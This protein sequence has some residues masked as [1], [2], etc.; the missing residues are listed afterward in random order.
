MR[1]R[2]IFAVLIVLAIEGLGLSLLM[3]QDGTIKVRINEA[4]AFKKNNDDVLDP[5]QDFYAINSIDGGAPFFTPEIGSRDDASWSNQI[6][7]KLV[8][9]RNQRFFDFYF[10]LWDRDT[11]CFGNV[12]DGFDISPQ[13]GPPGPPAPGGVFVPTIVTG[14]NPHVTYDVCTGKMQVVGVFG[15]NPIPIGSNAAEVNGYNTAPG[16]P[17]N[18]GS[19]RFDVVREPANWLPDD[20]AIDWVQIVQSV[21]K[22][23]RAVADKDTSLIVEI[24]STHPFP[25]TAPVHGQMTDGI[26]TVL[27]TKMVLIAPGSVATPG[28]TLVS[29]FDGNPTQPFKPQKSFIAGTGKVSGSASVDYAETISPNAPPQLMDCANLNNVGQATDLPL[30]HTSDPLTVFERFDYEEDQ[31][32]MTSPQLQ[33]MYTREET[34]RLASWPIANLNSSPT[35]NETWFDHGSDCLLCFEPFNTLVHYNAM[36]AQAGIDR[37]VLSVRNKWFAENAF[38]HQFIGAGSVGYSLGWFAPRA[39]L[40]EDGFYGVS[41]HE[42]GHTYNLS[43]HPCTNA[44]P[45]FGPGCYDEYTH[46]ASNGR[47]YE[48][49]GF[50]VSAKIYPSGIHVAPNPPYGDLACPTTPPQSRDICAPDLMDLVCG[51]GKD[52][53]GGYSGYQNWIDTFTFQYLMEN[54]LPHSDPFVVNVSGLIHFPNGQGDGSTAPLVEGFLPLFDYQFMGSQDLPDAPLSGVGE[55]F[56]G[57]GAFR[58]RLMTPVGVHDYRFNPR[59]FADPSRPDL[60]GGFS[61]SV[62]WDPSTMMVQLIGPSDARDTGCWN[63]LC[64]G[65]GII[66]DQRP[67]SP[68]PPSA[69]D[70]R[71]GR[72]SS[73][74]PTPP[75]ALPATPTIGPGHVAV[76][77]WG[78]FDPDS[79]ET[80]ASLIVMPPPSPVG[81]SGPPVPV[82]IDIVGTTFRIPQ[83]RMADAP[84][85]YTGR[86]LVSDGVN[87]TEIFNGALFNICNLSNGGVEFCN[88]LDDDCDGIVDNAAPPGAE[89]VQLNPQ[90]FPP[91]PGGTAT[92]MQ[93][94]ADPLAQSFDAVYG[95]LNILRDSGGNFT[96]ATLGCL[97]DN[98]TAPPVGPL[99][100]PPPG[101][102]FWFELR[103]NNCSGPGTYDSGDA[104]QVGSRDAEINASPRACR[105]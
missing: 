105:P 25:I 1:G 88:G 46:P 12:D 81:P 66:L 32:F 36:A 43:Q 96:Q 9:G 26:T 18:W 39:V 19:L 93:W 20:V 23:S 99:P 86:L 22:A 11:C 37:M 28:I 77:D 30:M 95:D 29:L 90:P 4:V 51:I 68:T 53:G 2:V 79:P 55:V 10:E 87:T 38:R 64:E 70:L 61:I 17:D 83:E 97:A 15:S 73:A 82:A 57:V 52:C 65:D 16:V 49:E 69:S 103:G 62:P 27:D 101:H 60:I 71:A 85:P 14:S 89:Q 80:R 45:P 48:A 98:V 75:G 8:P 56:S 74:P 31:R 92:M 78:A 54:T 72:D 33:A 24:S 42:L 40:A 34:Y 5:Q 6:N 94:V 44:S 41:T 63:K 59:F 102:A 13:N 67:V 84:G 91:A 7:L 21:Y 3:A 104:A 100:D 76:V 50:D 47:P 58:I 35:F